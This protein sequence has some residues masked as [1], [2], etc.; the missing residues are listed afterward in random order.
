MIPEPLHPA[1]V[2]FP[3]VLAVLS[4]PLAAAAFWG[5]RSGRTPRRSW[6]AVLVLQIGLVLTAWGA[7]ETGERDEELVERVVAER[8]IEAHEEAGERFLWLA[9][10]VLPVAAAGLLAGRAGTL[11]RG[12]TIALSLAVLAAAG[13][14]G[15][16]G[17]E[18]VYR[19]GAAAAHASPAPADND[20]PL[21][22]TERGDR[23]EEHDD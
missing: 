17:G 3:I 4:P 19:H 22:Y 6:A 18:L 11:G 16:S 23:H 21:A 1:L 13:A 2:H 14:V 10:A 7:A 9:A 12:L 20:S 8:H 5:I 15:H